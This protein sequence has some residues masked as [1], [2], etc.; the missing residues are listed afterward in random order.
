MVSKG[1]VTNFLREN[2]VTELAR[3]EITR[4][5]DNLGERARSLGFANTAAIS[6]RE[7]T[8][9]AHPRC[10]EYIHSAIVA[11]GT[12]RLKRAV[13]IERGGATEKDGGIDCERTCNQIPIEISSMSR[14]KDDDLTGTDIGRMKG[15]YWRVLE[16]EG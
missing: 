4:S 15:G 1:G 7:H 2:E 5:E 10:V 9:L 6:K 11:E 3:N 16:W 8:L 12:R 14:R 13:R